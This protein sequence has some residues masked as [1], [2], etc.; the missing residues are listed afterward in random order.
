[1]HHHFS[2]PIAAAASKRLFQILLTI[3]SAVLVY[4][5]METFS[6]AMHWSFDVYTRIR[7]VPLELRDGSKPGLAPSFSEVG[8]LNNLCLLQ[9]SGNEWRNG[10]LEV[11]FILACAHL[12]DAWITSEYVSLL[13]ATPTV[14]YP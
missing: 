10:T 8:L 7:V 9:P 2:T 4:Q 5:G 13:F 6:E 14:F 1:L 11:H 12:K 3:I